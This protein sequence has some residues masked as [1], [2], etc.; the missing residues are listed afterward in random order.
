MVPTK[1]LINQYFRDSMWMSKIHIKIKG[2][3]GIKVAFH[4]FTPEKVGGICKASPA[5]HELC[6]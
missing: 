5:N 4:S 1:N 2:K 6:Y 3:A